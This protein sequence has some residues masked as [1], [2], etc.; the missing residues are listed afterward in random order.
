[1]DVD[2]SAQCGVLAARFIQLKGTPMETIEQYL[3]Q[4]VELISQGRSTL[5]GF[6][7]ME[8]DVQKIWA[9]LNSGI[10]DRREMLITR[11]VCKP[12]SHVH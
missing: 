1:L 4:V 10:E 6:D 11:V 12:V 8:I 2:V 3:G 5:I 9:R 7:F